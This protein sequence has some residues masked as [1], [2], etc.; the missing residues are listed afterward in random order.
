MGVH[1]SFVRSLKM[2]RWKLKEL[3]AMEL[4]GNKNALEYYQ[5]HDMIRDGK[6]D[7]EAA[8]H[9]RYKLDLAQK[10]DALMKANNIQIGGAKPAPQ[11]PPA[12]AKAQEFKQPDSLANP[13][14][15]STPSNAPQV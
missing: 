9:A 11:Q 7:H 1:I 13:F 2:D 3:Y 8:A 4:G 12:Q 15:M 5:Q 6:P 10:C 14:D